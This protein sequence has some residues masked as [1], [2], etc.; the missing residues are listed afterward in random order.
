LRR[1]F[2]LKRDEVTGD[3]RGLRND[4]IKEKG[5]QIAWQIDFGGNARR[6]GTTRR[7]MRSLM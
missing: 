7:D 3:W 5:R 2:Q 4:K 6:N 1:I